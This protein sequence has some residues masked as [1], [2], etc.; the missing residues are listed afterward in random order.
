[1]VIGPTVVHYLS[2]W[3][4]PTPRTLLW[5]HKVKGGGCY[6]VVGIFVCC[7]DIMGNYGGRGVSHVGHFF[8]VGFLLG[9]D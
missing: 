9:G 3:P 8:C 2:R 1:M 5:A 4:K 6:G 7:M